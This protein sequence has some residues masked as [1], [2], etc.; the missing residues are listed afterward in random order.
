[1]SKRLK[2]VDLPNGHSVNPFHVVSV[3]EN[4][5]EITIFLAYG[6]IIRLNKYNAD[7]THKIEVNDRRAIISALEAATDFD[8]MED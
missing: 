8:R 3:N 1:M 7:R 2:F 5:D 4:I 6:P